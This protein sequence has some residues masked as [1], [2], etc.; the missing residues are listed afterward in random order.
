[1]GIAGSAS[2]GQLQVF[3]ALQGRSEGDDPAWFQHT[4]YTVCTP[5]GKT[6]LR[7]NNTAGYYEKAPRSI[8]LPEGRYLVKAQAKDYLRV[9]VPVVIERGRIT[10]VHLDDAWAL[11]ATSKETEVVSVPAGYPVGWSAGP[12]KEVRTN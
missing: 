9:H 11:P 6:L 10:R 2:T 7:V 1:A 12:A 8:T 4:G 5:S 3:S